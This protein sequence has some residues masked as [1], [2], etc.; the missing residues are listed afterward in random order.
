MQGAIVA[1]LMILLF[2]VH[3]R[4]PD[5]RKIL[6]S[7]YSHSITHLKYTSKVYQHVFSLLQNPGTRETGATYLISSL[8]KP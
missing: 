4:C 2:W 7:E 8:A 1:V 3:T 5:F 6:H